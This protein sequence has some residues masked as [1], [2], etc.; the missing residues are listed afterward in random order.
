MRHIG[1]FILLMLWVLSAWP[2]RVGELPE[3]MD[4]HMIAVSRGELFVLDGAVVR[5]YSLDLLTWK[6]SFGREGEGPGEMK[7]AANRKNH[8]YLT[9]DTVFIDGFDKIIS[10]SRAGKILREQRKTYSHFKV[11]PLGGGYVTLRR[12]VDKKGKPTL[13]VTLCDH[14]FQELKEL[15]VQ[16]PRVSR[17][18]LELFPDTLN[19]WVAGDKI[20]VERSAKGFVVDVFDAAGE[21]LVRINRSIEKIAITSRDKQE[22]MASID[23]DPEIRR[24]ENWQQ[25]KKKMDFPVPE[26]FPPIREITADGRRIYIQTFHQ[27]EGKA[28]FIILDLS[29]QILARPFLPVGPEVILDD[30]LS[31]MIARYYTFNDEFYFFVQ[32]NQETE[33]W[34]LHAL[35]WRILSP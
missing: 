31:G 3:V 18:V 33:T 28:E 25:V 9:G 27:M 12:Q 21:T 17:F 34:E 14:N 1:I 26:F 22:K 24:I 4:P 7:L 6:R 23:R 5:V 8:L 11:Q 10:F 13:A 16:A 15:A 29:G 35:R 20:F 30:E 19:F 32:E 2:D